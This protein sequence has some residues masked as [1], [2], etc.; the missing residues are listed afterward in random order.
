MK[1]YEEFKE[2]EDMWDDKVRVLVHG[3]DSKE[4]SLLAEVPGTDKRIEIS[5]APHD[6]IIERLIA[7]I[8]GLSTEEKLDLYF[9]WGL[10]EDNGQGDPILNK[11]SGDMYVY[12]NTDFAP[13]PSDSYDKVVAALNKGVDNF[14]RGSQS[15]LR[16][17]L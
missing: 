14:K 17:Y 6:I 5:C 8:T 3:S 12:D 11:D 4:S 16:S 13:V 10:C 15:Y 7:F 2:Y 1:L 9:H